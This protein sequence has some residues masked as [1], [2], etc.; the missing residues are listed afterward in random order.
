MIRNALNWM[1]QICEMEKALQ[2][3]PV[4][5]PPEKE[6][7]TNVMHHK[8]RKT[9]TNRQQRKSPWIGVFCKKTSSCH[10]YHCGLSNPNNWFYDSMLGDSWAVPAWLNDEHPWQSPASPWF[11]PLQFPCAFSLLFN[12]TVSHCLTVPMGEQ[13]THRLPSSWWKQYEDRYLMQHVR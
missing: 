13:F 10:C 12:L 9:R 3:Q 2:W 5:L 6:K 4:K 11:I 1:H 7:R 8:M